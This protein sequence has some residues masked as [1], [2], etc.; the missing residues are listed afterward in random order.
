MRNKFVMSF[1]MSNDCE[2]QMEG[3]CEQCVLAKRFLALK[4]K[5]LKYGY[6]ITI[7]PVPREDS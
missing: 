5:W 4:K 3:L 6:L 1:F 2:I 7:Q